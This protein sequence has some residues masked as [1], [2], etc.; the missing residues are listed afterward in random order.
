LLYEVENY[1]GFCNIDFDVREVFDFDDKGRIYKIY[2][3]DGFV[4]VEYTKFTDA[5]LSELRYRFFMVIS[6]INNF[7]KP[8]N[9]VRKD[10]SYDAMRNSYYSFYVYKALRFKVE[11]K[12]KIIFVFSDDLD[13]ALQRARFVKKNLNFLKNSN[14]H[15]Y[16]ELLT[17]EKI[18]YNAA[19]KSLDDLT[20]N[21]KKDNLF[22][23]YAGF[24]WFFHFWA[25]D[26][27]ISLGAFIILGKYAFVKKILFKHLERICPDGRL[28][29]R[30][31]VAWIG[32]ADAIGWLV[33][34]F[35]DFISVLHEKKILDKFLDE[36]ELEFVFTKIDDSID[37]IRENFEKQGLIHSHVKETWMD[38]DYEGDSREGACIEIQALQLCVYS[39]M[40]FLA[41]LLKKN[42][43]KYEKLEKSLAKEVKERF[44]NGSILAD[45]V[46]VNPSFI[47]RPNIFLAYYVYPKLLKKKEWISVFKNTIPQLWLKWGGLSTIEKTSPLFSWHYT[48]ENN[49]SYHRGDSWF[50]INNLAALC[51]LHLD[52]KLFKDYAEK[53]FKTSTYELLYKG[54]I[55]HCAE[56][57]PAFE[58]FSAGCLSQ[59]WSAAT[60]IELIEE[61]EKK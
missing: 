26:E 8:N 28:A 18:T 36:K 4:V 9:W 25:R 53:I 1:D 41:G 43:S 10:Y 13:I 20:V 27:L 42:T 11:N 17:K 15:Y 14:A 37:K 57:S 5:S 52:K 32:S 22:G 49:I 2:E 30:D 24:P 12:M 46:N 59:A 58:L 34:R 16:Q 39:F 50:F 47:A 48:G 40:G 6:G 33:K 61:K 7:E 55:G 45:V 44:F 21:S 38:T 56:L 23:I 51:M 31:P 29:N 3:K 54:F 35:Y 19:I 60:L